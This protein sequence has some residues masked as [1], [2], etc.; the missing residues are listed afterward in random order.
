MGFNNLN[1]YNT[2]F[3]PCPF[4]VGWGTS[5]NFTV[6]C[7]RTQCAFFFF[8]PS[9]Q[10]NIAQLPALG[11]SNEDLLYTYYLATHSTTAN[12]FHLQ[13]YYF[14]MYLPA[15]KTQAKLLFLPRVLY[16][17]PPVNSHPFG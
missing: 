8:L 16:L 4:G 15:H 7:N 3:Y 14:K 5:Q 2:I 10:W 13:I 9:F 17:L 6:D 11:S 1:N 12:I